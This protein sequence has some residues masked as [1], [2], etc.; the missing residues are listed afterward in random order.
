MFYHLIIVGSDYTEGKRI[1]LHYTSDHPIC[2]GDVMND[3]KYIQ[4]ICGEDVQL[5]IHKMQT[6]SKEWASIINKDSFFRDIKVTKDKEVFAALIRQ[7]RKINVYDVSSFI[8]SIIPCTQLKL[9]KLIYLC[10]ADFYKKYKKKMFEEKFYAFK[11]GPVVK[12]IRQK[13][14]ARGREK[15]NDE[16]DLEISDNLLSPILARIAFSKNGKEIGMSCLETLKKYGD[17][18]PSELVSITHSKGGPWAKVY[19]DNI[20]DIC[21]EDEIIEKYHEFEY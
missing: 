21:I 8:L 14:K 16:I 7:S 18:S 9:Q 3:F 6:T 1:A 10:Y 11:Y 5:S 12:E 17:K 15:I 13:Y 2:G 19:K 20:R 4:K